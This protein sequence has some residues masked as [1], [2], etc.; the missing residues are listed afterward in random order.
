[1]NRRNHPAHSEHGENKRS[2]WPVVGRA[3]PFQQRNGDGA[4]SQEN[5]EAE[6]ED[7]EPEAA[8]E[9]VVEPG[10]EGAEDERGDAAVIEAL[11]QLL[12]GGRV[13]GQRVVEKREAQA[14]NG[15]E[16]ERSEHQLVLETEGFRVEVDRQQDK[17]HAADQVSP[18]VDCFCVD[19]EDG[20]KA[21][22]ERVKRWSVAC[23]EVVVVL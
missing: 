5:D 14:E 10:D 22:S 4:G 16:E 21:G 8:V 1:M 11:E 6:V 13:A 9:P 19:V 7:A 12:D 15:A 20:F 2:D 23:Q 3:E 18:D 17:H